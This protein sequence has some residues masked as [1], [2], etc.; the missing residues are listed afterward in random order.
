MTWVKD[1]IDTYDN[2]RDVE[3]DGFVPFPHIGQIL[4]KNTKNFIDV[5]IDE[6]G[7]FIGASVYVNN[8]KKFKNS[9][10]SFPATEHSAK[11]TGTNAIKAPHALT[12]KLVYFILP[13]K[14]DS[15]SGFDIYLEN[16][17]EWV[18]FS[19]SCIQIKSIYTVLKNL[20]D[21]NKDIRELLKLNITNFKKVK[22]QN[23]WSCYYS[24]IIRW[25]V[26]TKNPDD[27][28]KTWRNE[29]VIDSWEKFTIHKKGL[30]DTGILDYFSGKDEPS[31]E[32]YGKPI[33]L[34]GSGKLISFSTNEDGLKNYSGERFLNSRDTKRNI[35][36]Y[37]ARLS[38]ISAQKLEC[39]LGWIS[40]NQSIKLFE[41]DPNEL[42]MVW[43]PRLQENKNQCTYDP[44]VKKST[45]FTFDADSFNE[46]MYKSENE[47]FCKM[48]LGL[49]NNL[50]EY[51]EHTSIMII[52]KSTIGRIT[53]TLYESYSTFEYMCKLRSWY[54]KCRFYTYNPAVKKYEERMISLFRIAKCYSSRE[55]QKGDSI[56]FEP[57]K[58]AY[59]FAFKSLLNSVLHSVPVPYVIMQN[60]V[61]KASFPG[62]YA[63]S[64]GIRK[65]WE[66]VVESA[67]AMIR[68]MHM[69]KNP[70][71]GEKDMSLDRESKNV[72][73]LFGRLLAVM[74]RIEDYALYLKDKENKNRR[75]TNAKRL[76]SAYVSRPFSTFNNLRSN[77]QPYL[78]SLNGGTRKRFE[79]EI[80]EIINGLDLQKD[81][82]NKPLQPEYLLGFY[83]ERKELIEKDK[84]K[85]VTDNENKEEKTND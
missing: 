26:V 21:S 20:R 63:K 27:E 29:E 12:D 33:K 5:T 40:E 82:L 75:D 2:F 70:E 1:L 10:T 14:Q 81:N 23:D 38:Y 67:C 17:K 71:K 30:N 42:L 44:N 11:R 4:I 48:L 58:H 16:M 6:N 19:P 32:F 36:S 22:D 13:D 37:K 83:H 76:W 35:Q 49:E 55:I 47:A 78:S 52:S 77:I 59:I 24:H 66:Y 60:I 61:Q 72:S 39:A 57:S 74:D 15:E 62:K 65:N 45:V 28:T 85:K 51:P 18:D 25:I 80:T 7:K 46:K 69:E 53:P 84:D 9:S 34:F 79:D 50:A 54:E 8:D 64:G 41:N 56:L 73:Y 3:V 68:Y 31:I 43:T